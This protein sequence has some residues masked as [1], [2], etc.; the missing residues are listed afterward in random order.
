[1]LFI[2]YKIIQNPQF[3]CSL[4][5]VSIIYTLRVINLL[6]VSI[7]YTITVM[8]VVPMIWGNTL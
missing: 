6:N 1:M 5:H 4:L 8:S 3:L 2:V 7:I